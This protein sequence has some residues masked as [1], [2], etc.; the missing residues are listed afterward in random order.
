MSQTDPPP[1]SQSLQDLFQSLQRSIL[2]L[3]HE[4]EELQQRL[5]ASGEEALSAALP[6][7]AKLEGL[8]RDC[9]KVEKTL[10]EHTPEGR[11][12]Q[13]GLDLVAARAEISSRLD[14]LRTAQRAEQPDR[15]DE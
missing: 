4:A 14:R 3:R 15:G 11:A 6:R 12:D 9:Q 8:I 10:V 13:L 7:I 2:R 5:A 1:N